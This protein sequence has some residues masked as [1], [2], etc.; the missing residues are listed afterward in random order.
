VRGRAPTAHRVVWC[1]RVSGRG[2]RVSPRWQQARYR[3]RPTQAAGR[4]P[5]AVPDA[6]AAEPVPAGVDTAD[7]SRRVSCHAETRSSTRE[8]VC[9][10]LHHDRAGSAP[11]EP[12]TASDSRSSQPDH[13]PQRPAT[14]VLNPCRDLRPH[15]VDLAVH[16]GSRPIIWADHWRSGLPAGTARNLANSR[17]GHSAVSG[18]SCNSHQSMTDC[19]AAAA[20]WSRPSRSSS[21]ALL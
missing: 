10:R 18:A 6:A 3:R 2:S 20:S 12:G 16:R 17:L 14:S 13:R 21:N 19:H 15:V 8:R 4:D 5:P 9:G 1:V 7:D 11:S